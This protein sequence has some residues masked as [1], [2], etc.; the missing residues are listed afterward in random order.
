MAQVKISRR[1]RLSTFTKQMLN[2][3]LYF[4]SEEWQSGVLSLP[5]TVVS[6]ASAATPGPSQTLDE[7]KHAAFR[8]PAAASTPESF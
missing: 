7:G 2:K 8:G 6:S 1:S 3:Y 4:Q 5:F